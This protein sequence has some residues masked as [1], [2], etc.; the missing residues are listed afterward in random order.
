M[1]LA[2]FL[3]QKGFNVDNTP[4]PFYRDLRFVEERLAWRIHRAREITGKKV[5]VVGHSTGAVMSLALARRV[6]EDI[7][8][9]IALGLPERGSEFALMISFLPSGRQLFPWHRYMKNMVEDSFPPEVSLYL[10]HGEGDILVPRRFLLFPESGNNISKVLVK[11]AGHLS[12]IEKEVFPL[13]YQI[14]DGSFPG[15]EGVIEFDPHPE[16]RLEVRP[17]GREGL[18][19]RLSFP[20]SSFFPG[21]RTRSV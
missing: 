9:V 12:L 19:N 15:G 7:D 14:L 18:W 13:I 6:P 11:N 3:S 20:L 8:R 4:Y 2:N 10:I 5:D 16:S 21:R 17:E 1:E